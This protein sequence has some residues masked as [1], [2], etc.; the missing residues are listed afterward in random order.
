[1]LER[2]RTLGL[3]V[4][5]Q[6]SGRG[7][8]H[9]VMSRKIISF[10]SNKSR[11][12]WSFCWSCSAGWRK[13]SVIWL[14]FSITRWLR[15]EHHL[16]VIYGKGQDRTPHPLPFLFHHDSNIVSVLWFLSGKPFWIFLA[17]HGNCDITSLYFASTPLSPVYFS[18]HYSLASVHSATG[19]PAQLHD[20]IQWGLLGCFFQH[21]WLLPPL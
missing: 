4:G 13:W 3:C 19:F 12:C 18:A 10:S 6:S 9:S 7:V 14:A 20:W 8:L 11:I 5:E 15:H 2:K 17:N 1:M 16:V 21:W